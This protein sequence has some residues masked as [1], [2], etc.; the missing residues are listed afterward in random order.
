MATRHHVERKL[1][2]HMDPNPKEKIESQT[3]TTLSKITKKCLNQHMQRPSM[4]QILKELEEVL[5]LHESKH[6]D[7]EPPA[8]AD[9]GTSSS[10]L[11]EDIECLE[12]PLSYIKLA[13]NDFDEACLIGE[14]GYGEVYRADIR[15]LD[16][17]GISTM[18]GR[19]TVAIKRIFNKEGQSKEEFFEEVDMLNSCKHQNIVSLLGISTEDPEMILVCEFA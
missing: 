18:A 14:G 16:F 3:L 1:D 19:G 11:K 6:K 8:N 12:I 2:E 5:E 13:T 15:H 17:Q 4:D 10:R 7:L 9:E